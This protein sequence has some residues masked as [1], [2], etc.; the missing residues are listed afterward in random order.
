MTGRTNISNDTNELTGLPGSVK[1]GVWSS[2]TLPN[3]CG[4]PGCM[5]TLPN[6]T[7]PSADSTSLTVS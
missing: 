3:P 1:I 4:M 7:V 6:H 2:P 5:A